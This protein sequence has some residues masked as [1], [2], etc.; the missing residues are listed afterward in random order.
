M[1]GNLISISKLD[2]TTIASS[3]QSEA[4]EQLAKSRESYASNTSTAAQNNA[5]SA[6]APNVVN[7]HISAARPSVGWGKDL[8]DIKQLNSQAS[9]DSYESQGLK[10]DAIVKSP[11]AYYPSKNLGAA[12]NTASQ[13]QNSGQGVD[14]SNRVNAR[15]DR[16]GWG[17]NFGAPTADILVD[18]LDSVATGSSI[19]LQDIA[20]NAHVKA[21]GPY[22]PPA[23]PS[24]DA[25]NTASQAANS[26]QDVTSVNRVDITENIG[27]RY[28]RPWN[29]DP[30]VTRLNSTG[31]GENV[32]VQSAAQDALS[33]A[34]SYP[35]T[36]AANTLGQAQNSGQDV[37]SRNVVNMDVNDRVN[38]FQTAIA[39]TLNSATTATNL[40]DQSGTQSAQ[41]TYRGSALNDGA[42]A[43]NSGQDA[44]SGNWVNVQL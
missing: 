15:V 9:A 32:Q 21:S 36:T 25:V 12:L 3:A 44:D 40:Q 4:L 22:C 30:S 17:L 19:Q 39:K 1:L 42:Q 41:S 24:G 20:E 7:A 34:R 31:A 5:Q 2:A 16:P 10:Q 29:P 28:I 27:G 11:V 38:A 35:G 37:D 33:E 43:Q 13:A 23:Y 6:T 8:I 18:K 14:S 26:G